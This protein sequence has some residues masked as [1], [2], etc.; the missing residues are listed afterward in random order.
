ML[1]KIN[2]VAAMTALHNI[3]KLL[4]EYLIGSP[5]FKIDQSSFIK[6]KPINNNSIDNCL[7]AIDRL[8][9]S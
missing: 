5:P 6:S 4:L 1:F 9:Y 2:S 3:L 8:Y 7:G